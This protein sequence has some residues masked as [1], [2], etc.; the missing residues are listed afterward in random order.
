MD[1]NRIINMV[2][3]IFVAQIIRRGISSG[4]GKVM[5]NRRR[6]NSHK[7]S[8]QALSA[9]K[10]S[11]ANPHSD[12]VRARMDGLHQDSTHQEVPLSDAPDQVTL[13]QSNTRSDSHQR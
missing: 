12:S 8:D 2:V 4:L 7:D 6:T 13:D 5:G 1:M 9:G 3:R 11:Q 10:P